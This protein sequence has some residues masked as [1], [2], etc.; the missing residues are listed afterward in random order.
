MWTRI[1]DT[2]LCYYDHEFALDQLDQLINYVLITLLLRNRNIDIVLYLLDFN[3]IVENNNEKR[4][5]FNGK[6][7]CTNTFLRSA[8]VRKSW[9]V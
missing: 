3:S 4:T 5:L 9:G 2:K 8:G 6:K 1:C 7:K